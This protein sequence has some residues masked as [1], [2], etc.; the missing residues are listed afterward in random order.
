MKDV[1][2]RCFNKTAAQVCTKTSPRDCLHEKNLP[3]LN[4]LLCCH[5]YSAMLSSHV[6]ELSAVLIII[7][8]TAMIPCNILSSC[9]IELIAILIMIVF[10]AMIVV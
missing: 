3:G 2:A 9:I 8:L 6:I 5:D 4:I 1:F 10:T 7:V